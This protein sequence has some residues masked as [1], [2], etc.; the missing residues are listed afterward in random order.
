MIG[1]AYLFIGVGLSAIG[2]VM[3]IIGIIKLFFD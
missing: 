3:A 1:E 2:S